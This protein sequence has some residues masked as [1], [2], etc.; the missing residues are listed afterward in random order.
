MAAPAS[1][2]TADCGTAPSGG[3]MTRSGNV[4]TLT[5]DTAGEYS[6]TPSVLEDLQALAVGGGGGANAGG[7]TGYSG[8]GGS[9]IY[10]DLS[11]ETA[12]SAITITVGVGGTTGRHPID[13]EVSIIDGD[14]IFRGEGGDSGNI[15]HGY[16]ALNGST[17]TYV[18]LGEGAKRPSNTTNGETCGTPGVGINPS[19]GDVDTNDL[20][21]PSLFSDFSVELGAGGILRDN[22]ALPAQ[23]PGQGGSVNMNTL[24]T[25]LVNST[26]GKDGIVVFRWTSRSSLANTGSESARLGALAGG[27]IALGAGLMVAGALRR[28]ATR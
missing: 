28:K 19:I 24:T 25:E 15:T 22:T 12:G 20:A 10:A 13:G 14:G 6:W 26:N 9:V 7:S 23:K 5:F 18:G 2:S 8:R 3:T 27:T 11:H 16:C 17:S 1:A 21:V 4:C